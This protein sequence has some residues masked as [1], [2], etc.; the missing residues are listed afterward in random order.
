MKGAK[1]TAHAAKIPEPIQARGK[2]ERMLAGDMVYVNACDDQPWAQVPINTPP[3]D[4]QVCQACAYIVR[5]NREV[6]TN[7][8]KP[9]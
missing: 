7:Q 9:G 4:V 3:S 6:R 2:F 1:L 5:V 8:R